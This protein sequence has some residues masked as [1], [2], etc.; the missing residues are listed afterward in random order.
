[1][2]AESIGLHNVRQGAVLKPSVGNKLLNSLG[3]ACLLV[4][5]SNTLAAETTKDSALWAGGLFLFDRENG[6]NYSLEYQIRLNDHMS[7]LS[8]HF[9]EFTGYRKTTPSLLL[10]GAYRYTRRTD[11]DENRLV[12]GG[13]WDL[14]K[15]I[16]PA[17][18]DPDRFKAVLQ[19]GYQHD[20]DVEFDD[21]LMD[22]NSIRW[23]LVGSKPVTDIITPFF[24]AG[25]LT[26]W[27]EAYNFGVDKI[28]LGGGISWKMTERSRLRCQYIFERA[29]FMTPEKKTNIIWLRYEAILGK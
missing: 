3:M 16:S 17:W 21:E 8:S 9:L 19:I 24:I 7:S 22:S 28:R 29:Y 25:V 26:S 4:C 20:F 15:T 11:H 18:N 5:L 14:T 6:L 10:Y 2:I 23:I 27:N 12:I 13:F 1:M